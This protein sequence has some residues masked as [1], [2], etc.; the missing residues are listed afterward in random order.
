MGKTEVFHNLGA[1]TVVCGGMYT[2][3]FSDLGRLR[4]E[5]VQDHPRLHCLNA[6]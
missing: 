5:G 3:V 2:P 4:Q 6:G 1:V